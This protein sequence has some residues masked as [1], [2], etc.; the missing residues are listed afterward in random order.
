MSPQAADHLGNV[1][2]CVVPFRLKLQQIFKSALGPL[3]LRTQHCFITHIHGHKKVRVG[4]DGRTPI[5]TPQGEVGFG[6][7]IVEFRVAGYG[8]LWGKRRWNER[9][10]S[11]GLRLKTSCA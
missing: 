5:K 4:Q 2:C 10:V 8:R 9:P 1:F 6:K 3:N 11:F 7:Q